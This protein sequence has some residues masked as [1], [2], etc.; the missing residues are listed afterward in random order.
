MKLSQLKVDRLTYKGDGK[1]KHIVYDE[2]RDAPSGF[3]VRM[4]P[5][6]RKSYILGYR[7]RPGSNWK[8]IVLGDAVNIDSA[9][10][11]AKK[12]KIKIESDVD[13]IEAKKKASKVRKFADVVALYQENKL[14]KLKPKTQLGHN[15]RI[16]KKLL[17]TFGKRYIDDI[18]KEKVE[19]FF[20]QLK[21]DTPV[22]AN[23][24]LC[25]LSVIF[26]YAI[27]KE[28]A[29][30]NPCKKIV[31]VEEKPRKRWLSTSDERERFLKA[32][33]E[34]KPNDA[35]YFFMLLLTSGLRKGEALRLRWQD[36]NFETGE[37]TLPTTKTED[38]Q[39]RTVSRD[40]LNLLAEK[41]QQPSENSPY[42][43]PS[44]KNP[45]QYAEDFRRAWKRIVD[46]AELTDF[47]V[48]DLRATFASL[49]VNQGQSLFVLRDLLGHSTTR[50]L[51]RRYGQ[52]SAEAKRS[53]ADA[54]GNVID[55]KT[56]K[57]T[58]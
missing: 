28:L 37:V 31:Q 51:D 20:N 45:L 58:A 1:S 53:A 6:G 27:E 56:L 42:V 35:Y 54:I 50:M 19:K 17:P 55:F 8:V 26:E 43:F 4:Y 3:G 12:L 34:E 39:M 33:T 48:H 14:P 25:L 2:H 24:C 49:L 22:E 40:A 21:T 52:N 57:K 10:K 29:S 38:N 11:Q 9:R 41:R 32:V 30:N 36:I 18:T 16:E 47:H 44:P 13:P 23:R 7:M 15:N 46:R 5:S